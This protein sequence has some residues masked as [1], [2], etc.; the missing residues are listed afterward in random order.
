M[1]KR[2]LKNSIITRRGGK[3]FRGYM[4]DKFPENP[5]R[6]VQ[7]L[8]CYRAC[9]TRHFELI[10]EIIRRRNGDV[11]NSMWLLNWYDDFTSQRTFNKN[12]LVD[13]PS[14][15]LTTS[16]ETA[17]NYAY[18]LNWYT[19]KNA[20]IM[21]FE[22]LFDFEVKELKKPPK[23]IGE[24]MLKKQLIMIY[25]KANDPVKG[26]KKAL[27]KE[28]LLHLPGLITSEYLTLIKLKNEQTVKDSDYPKEEFE[29]LFQ[30]VKDYTN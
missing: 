23:K 2:Q 30:G 26:L 7:K 3:I 10:E 25:E 21:K 28:I 11:I 5:Q 29:L 24:E 12:H 18:Y 4:T 22:L 1:M 19:G 6:N 9:T 16:I 14:L 17:R 15:A 20:F 8:I 13:A 27:G